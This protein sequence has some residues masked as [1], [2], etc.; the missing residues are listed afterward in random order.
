[1]ADLFAATG[2]TLFDQPVSS[3]H[4]QRVAVEFTPMTG[5]D[6]GVS[7]AGNFRIA[8]ARDQALSTR[9]AGT[10]SIDDSGSTITLTSSCPAAG[11]STIAYDSTS[12]CDF[13]LYFPASFLNLSASDEAVVLT[14][15]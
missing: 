11:V 7:N 8:A 1:M 13:T 2:V 6:G 14:C 5:P 4:T 9:I 12:S 15:R 3:T 10:Y